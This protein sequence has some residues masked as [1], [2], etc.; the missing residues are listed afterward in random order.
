MTDVTIDFLSKANPIQRIAEDVRRKLQAA[1]QSRFDR[2]FSNGKVLCEK[3]FDDLKLA[4]TVPPEFVDQP[5]E[6][7]GSK[8]FAELYSLFHELLVSSSIAGETAHLH[9][10]NLAQRTQLVRAF[11]SPDEAIERVTRK[12]CEI[13]DTFPRSAADIEVGRNP[14][15]VL[16]PYILAATQTLLYNGDFQQAIGATV[17]HKALMVIEGL[18]GHLH[19]DVIGD[20][21]GNIRAPEPRGFNQEILD[22]VTNPFP[23][24]DV[25]QPPMVAGERL[26]VHQVKS[27]TGSAKGGDGKRLGEQLK[28]L[29]QYYD[30]DIFYDALIGNTLRGHRSMGAVIAA[31]PDVTVLVGEAA[32]YELTKSR[33]GPELL[34]RVYQNAF[35]EA[36]RISGY[37]IEIM[38]STIVATFKERAE[39]AGEGFFELLLNDSIGGPAEF[40]SSKLYVRSG[41]A[42]KRS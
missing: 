27:K 41:R 23:G 17:A 2:V 37:H 15:D 21:R 30:A 35:A 25:V 20:M 24:A 11:S 13:V 8:P 14:G 39:A 16:D 22:P 42:A 7:L 38:A 5:A 36:A 19:E 18:M 28:R 32:F 40:Q 12:V 33:I 10:V 6:N 4:L 9:A 29:Q 1:Q 34:L 31:A 26:R 3:V